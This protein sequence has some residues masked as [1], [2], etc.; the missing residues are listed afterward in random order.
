MADSTI[1]VSDAN[2]VDRTLRTDEVATVHTPHHIVASSA[3]PALASTSTLQSTA[4]THLG[5]IAG[6]TTSLDGKVTTCNT[7]AVVLA[8]GTAEFGKLAAGTAN[9]GDVDVLTMPG[10]AAEGASLPSVFT[11]VAADD[12]SN[13][14]PLQMDDSTGGLKVILQAGS[15]SAGTVVLGAGSAAVGTVALG[16]GAASIG[17]LGANS[18]TDIGDVD[19]TS[20]AVP[21]TIYHGKKVVT[22]GTDEVIAGSQALKSGCTVKAL[23]GNAGIVYVGVETVASGTGFELSAKESVFIEIDNTNRIWLDAATGSA[24]G[25]TYIAS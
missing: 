12:G 11:V 23:A 20:V 16:A 5:T 25:I 21:T 15:A 19:V 14:Q 1:V 4:N 17:T 18:G 22:A 2:D 10:T 8:G 24:D 3:L 6:D 7:N 13:T 9:I